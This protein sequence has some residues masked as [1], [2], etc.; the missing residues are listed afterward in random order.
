MG[1]LA[2]VGTMGHESVSA[3]LQRIR[4]YAVEVFEDEEDAKEWL[5]RPNPALDG[6]R[7]IIVA[8][9]EEGEKL[10]RTALGR[11]DHGVYT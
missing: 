7:P 4:A 5:N 11:I 9:S 2:G 10:V 8:E 6:E 1:S 3:R